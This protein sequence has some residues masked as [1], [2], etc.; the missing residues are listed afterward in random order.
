METLNLKPEKS[1]WTKSPHKYVVMP[2]GLESF[3]LWVSGTQKNNIRE[4]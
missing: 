4:T 3:G 1:I 2:T